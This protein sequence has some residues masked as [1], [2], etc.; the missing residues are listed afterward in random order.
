MSLA[1]AD[2]TPV[3]VCAPSWSNDGR[4]ALL[5]GHYTVVNVS[6]TEAASLSDPFKGQSR[7]GAAAQTAKMSFGLMAGVFAVAVYLL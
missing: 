4:E 1:V 5:S 3:E 6:E 2:G 7:Q